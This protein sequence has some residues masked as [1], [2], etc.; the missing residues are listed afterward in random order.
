MED[1]T[2]IGVSRCLLGEKVRYD[3]GHKLDRYVTETLARHVDFVGVCPEVEY[4]L[5]TPRE[6]MHLV[7]NPED[8]RLVTTRSGI[9]HTDGMQKWAVQRVTKLESEGLAG[10]IFKSRSPSSGMQG[11]KVYGESGI[12]ATKGVGLFARAFMEHFPLIPVEDEGRLNDLRIRENFLERV[13]VYHRWQQFRNGTRTAGDFVEFHTDHKLLILSHSPKHYTELGRLVAAAR[14]YQGDLYKAYAGFLMEGL[15][16]M[17]TPRKNTNVLHHIMGYF[18][19]QL[20]GDEK[21][22]L[23]ELIGRYRRGLVPLIAPI[24]LLNH[25]VRK[26]DQPYLKH[27]YYLNPHPIELMLRNHV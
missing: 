25:Y 5:P 26:Y 2:K 1:K 19:N 21:E 22:E 17:A 23:L 4:G 27:Q 7:G 8:P 9:D 10:F 18:K 16:L 6:A 20:S 3:G 14:G 13:F 24:I 15:R 12:P 11:V